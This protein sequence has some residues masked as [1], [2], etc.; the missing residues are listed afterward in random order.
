MTDVGNLGPPGSGAYDS[1]RPPVREEI[2][3]QPV[4]RPEVPAADRWSEE[5]TAMV[6]IL[7]FA[8]AVL[9]CGLCAYGI[10]RVVRG[11]KE[12]RK[13]QQLTAR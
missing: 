13:G 7:I 10:S 9:C 6:T 5:V 3:P 12:R 4:E 11:A 1:V 8:A 2:G